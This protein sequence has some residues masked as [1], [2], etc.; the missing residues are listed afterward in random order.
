M[1]LDSSIDPQSSNAIGRRMKESL[2]GSSM[3]KILF[4]SLFF[5]LCAT[6]PFALRASDP[7]QYN[8]KWKII[9][10]PSAGKPRIA[11]LLLANF[12]GTWYHGTTT[13]RTEAKVCNGKEFP[14]TVAHNED[15]ELEFTAFGSSV[16][17][18][19]PDITV[20]VRPVNSNLLEGT[21]STGE[22][23]KLLRQ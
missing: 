20:E 9:I 13:V 21:L 1:E 3:R 8:G 16:S 15:T 23:V 2:T 7:D 10:Q 6:A 12:S 14:V 11:K 4:S 22:S 19:C 5:G 18:K 17:P